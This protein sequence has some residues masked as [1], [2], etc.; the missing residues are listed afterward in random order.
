VRRGFVRWKAAILA[1]ST[2][3]PSAKKSKERRG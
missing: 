2:D 3:A 1:R